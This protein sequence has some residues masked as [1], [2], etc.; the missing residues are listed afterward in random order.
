MNIGGLGHV[1]VYADEL[2]YTTYEV[3]TG[4][5][6]NRRIQNASAN[7]YVMNSLVF[8]N[9]SNGFIRG[10]ESW[11]LGYGLKYYLYNRPGSSGGI[12]E[13]RYLAIGIETLHI[14]RE[15]KSITK[16]LSL[17]MRPKIQVGTRLH[18]KI[19]S[20]YLFAA[21]TYNLYITNS[22]VAI[23]PDFLERTS[24]VNGRLLEQWP[25]LAAGIQI[26]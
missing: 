15:A 5:C 12:G 21:V 13:Y 3:A 8:S 4:N 23:S 7:R 10:R 19:Q 2:F 24:N 16:D 17:L 11:A 9:N 1:A 25:G 18:P 26:H 22:N 6:K 14:N 20:I